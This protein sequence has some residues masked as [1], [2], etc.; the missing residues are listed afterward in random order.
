MGNQDG[1]T[2]TGLVEHRRAGAALF[3]A[4][5]GGHDVA[6]LHAVPHVAE[7][8]RVLHRAVPAA[9]LAG[10]GLYV[11]NGVLLAMQRDWWG[12]RDWN[13]GSLQ[14]TPANPARTA[15]SHFRRRLTPLLRWMKG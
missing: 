13:P 2:V 9:V 11:A 5:P 6:R 14:S 10:G 8:L 4:L 3:R 12:A 1:M 15:R 7:L